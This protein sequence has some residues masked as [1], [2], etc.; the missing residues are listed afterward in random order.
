MD[1][2]EKCPFCG[3]EVIVDDRKSY[4]SLVSQYGSACLQAKCGNRDC[5]CNLYVYSMDSQNGGKYGIYRTY[6]GKNETIELY[7]ER[8]SGVMYGAE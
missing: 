2:W 3:G 8:K 1:G 7:L 4:Q 5:G 6:L